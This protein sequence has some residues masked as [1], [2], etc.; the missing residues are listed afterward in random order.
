MAWSKLLYQASGNNVYVI[1]V[2]FINC[3][4]N[5]SK[6]CP[7]KF[8]PVLVLEP[9]EIAQWGRALAILPEDLGSVMSTH[10]DAHNYL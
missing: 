10:M 7:E 1:Y 5:S 2:K 9:K 6:G 3:F 8:S 4:I